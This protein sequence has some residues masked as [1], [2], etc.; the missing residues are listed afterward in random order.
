MLPLTTHTR[1]CTKHVAENWHDDSRACARS[2]L[3]LDARGLAYLC[4][5]RAP[6]HH[7]LPEWR[8]TCKKKHVIWMHE[9]SLSPIRTMLPLKTHLPPHP[10]GEMT[11]VAQ[12]NGLG[13]W[14]ARR[15]QLQGDLRT[16]MLCKHCSQDYM[17]PG[18]GGGHDPADFKAMSDSA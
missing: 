3:N 8:P 2:M 13:S 11:Q 7:T 10:T 5:Q 18:W 6:T 15:L 12:E 9:D 4:P 16:H 1:K 14:D 17:C